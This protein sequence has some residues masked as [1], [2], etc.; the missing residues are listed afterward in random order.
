[1]NTVNHFPFSCKP[2]YFFH[3]KLQ[4]GLLEQLSTSVL[5]GN[6]DRY[7]IKCL[8]SN[9]TA[10]TNLDLAITSCNPKGVQG[11]IQLQLISIKLVSEI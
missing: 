6:L 11:G 9:L 5:Q 2:L 7:L 1:M 10:L 4:A 8:V 3:V